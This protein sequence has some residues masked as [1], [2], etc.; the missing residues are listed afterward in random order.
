MGVTPAGP[1]SLPTA[2]GPVTEGLLAGLR[3]RPG[4]ALPA[5]KGGDGWDEDLQLALYLC[6]ELHYRGFQR[7]DDDWEW[8]PELL[9]LRRD[10][11]SRFTETLRAELG[12]VPDVQ[13]QL[14]G[15][16]VEPLHGSGPSYFLRDRGERWQAR[17]YLAHRSLYHLKEADP[18]AWALPR[19]TGGPR[20]A[21]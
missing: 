13:E 4:T 18:Q 6:Y 5:A 21:C 3:A 11:E 16:L 12:P 15:L 1:P 7:V 2:R 14:D 8:D 19:L 9:R 17:E 20:R 10:L